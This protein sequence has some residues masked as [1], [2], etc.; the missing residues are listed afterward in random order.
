[1]CKQG[2]RPSDDG[3]KCEESDFNGLDCDST[4]KC[5]G[6]RR[7]TFC[8]VEVAEGE[9]TDATK[10]TCKPTCADGKRRVK[11]TAT[12]ALN[13]IFENRKGAF[14]KLM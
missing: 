11:M 8:D 10:C 12:R 2:F 1:M 4:G 9:F 5:A 6:C 7:G 13:E 14:M 3:T